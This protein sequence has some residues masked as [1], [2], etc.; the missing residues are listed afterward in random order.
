MTNQHPISPSQKLRDKWLEEAPVDSSI[1]DF[2]IDSASQWSADAELKACCRWLK[3][4]ACFEFLA[5]DLFAARRPRPPSLKEQALART[6]AILSDP[7]RALLIE[8][9]ETLELNL[10]ALEALPDE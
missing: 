3:H 10:R 6:T 1:Y 5:K 8:V 9:R 7:N 2:L 4:E